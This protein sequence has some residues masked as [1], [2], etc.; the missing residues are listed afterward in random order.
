LWT[1]LFASPVI[2]VRHVQ[3]NLSVSQPGATSLLRVLTDVG[4]LREVGTGAG[5]RYRWF[6]D[7]VLQVL[8]PDVLTGR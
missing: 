5:T 2:T 4:V 7:Q 3:D 1:F 8:D 6:A